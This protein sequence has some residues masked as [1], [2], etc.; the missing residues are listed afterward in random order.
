MAR[1]LRRIEP[2]EHQIQSA[3][4]EWANFTKIPKGVTFIGEYLIAIPNGGYR[5]KKEAAILKKEGVTAGVSD[6]F[7]ALP[8]KVYNGLWIECKSMGGRVSNYQLEWMD[9]MKKEGYDAKV[10]SKV[11]TGIQAIK[12]YLGIR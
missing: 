8:N 2:T 5:N 12:D 4:V 1:N 7:L 10:V 11:D 6:M 3:I 9:K